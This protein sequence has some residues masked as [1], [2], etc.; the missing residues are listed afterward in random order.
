MESNMRFGDRS[1]EGRKKRRNERRKGEKKDRKERKD[2]RI[3]YWKEGGG[4]EDKKRI[5]GIIRIQ[6]G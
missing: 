6:K 4:E 5:N 2:G 3:E 1:L